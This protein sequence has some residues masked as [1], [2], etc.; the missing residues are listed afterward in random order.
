[1]RSDRPKYHLR[2][3]NFKY[4][5]WYSGLISEFSE[6]FTQH[7][8]IIPCLTSAWVW[9]KT[10]ESPNTGSLFSHKCSSLLSNQWHHN[11][12]AFKDFWMLVSQSWIDHVLKTLNTMKLSLK[13]TPVGPHFHLLVFSSSPNLCYASKPSK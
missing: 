13:W 8:Y 7:C 5:A 10:K 11:Y 4:L 12:I 3:Q 1:L 6:Q 9:S 2:Y